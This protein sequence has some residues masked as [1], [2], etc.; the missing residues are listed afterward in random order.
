MPCDTGRESSQIKDEIGMNVRQ[1]FHIHHSSPDIHLYKHP[2][3]QLH[4]PSYSPVHSP[5]LRTT[6]YTPFNTVYPDPKQY[7]QPNNI[8]AFAFASSSVNRKLTLFTQCLSSV[9]VG[10]PSPLNTCPKCPPQLLHTI[11]VLSIPNELSVYRFTAPGME[12]KYAGHPQPDLNLCE[13]V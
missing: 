9:G 13:A 2:L 7:L 3:L 6:P 1:E 5:I 11:S 12:S 8:Y 4:T 10:Y